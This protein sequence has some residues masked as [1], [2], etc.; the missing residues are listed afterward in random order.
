MRY[1]CFAGTETIAVMNGVESY[2]SL[3]RSLKDCWDEINKLLDD[4]QIEIEP[5]VTV[6]VEIFLGGDY[7][8]G[9]NIIT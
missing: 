9:L 5:G 7:K 8:V 2:W 3:Q 6:P 4:G 1:T